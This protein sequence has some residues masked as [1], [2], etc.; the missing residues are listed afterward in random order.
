MDEY[1]NSKISEFLGSDELLK[2]KFLEKI[3]ILKFHREFFSG[4]DLPVQK[5]FFGRHSSCKKFL[6]NH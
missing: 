3:Q 5:N 2:L 1:R 6:K 4:P